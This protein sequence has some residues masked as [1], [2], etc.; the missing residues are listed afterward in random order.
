MALCEKCGGTGGRPYPLLYSSRED[1]A[2][3]APGTFTFKLSGVQDVMICDECAMGTFRARQRTLRR[4]LAGMIAFGAVVVG[5]ITWLGAGA[6]W[7]VSAMVGFVVLGTLIDLG[8]RREQRT[9]EAR[10]QDGGETAA[11]EIGRKVLPAGA[12]GQTAERWAQGVQEATGRK[13]GAVVRAEIRALIRELPHRTS[14][15]GPSA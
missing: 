8:I 3:P 5:V 10:L 7:G 6:L 11:A 1:V 9:D 13:D 2:V 4:S 15:G 14:V 12:V